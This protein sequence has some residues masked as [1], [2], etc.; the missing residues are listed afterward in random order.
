MQQKAE[1]AERVRQDFLHAWNGYKQYA[2]GHDELQP[3]TQ[4]LSRLV[5]PCDKTQKGRPL[6]SPAARRC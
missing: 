5:R 4:E 6:A 3:L 2:W 1:M